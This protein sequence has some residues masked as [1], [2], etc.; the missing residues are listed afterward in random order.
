MVVTAGTH[1]APSIK[2]AEASKIIENTQRDL[3]IALINELTKLF[4]KLD[5][6]INS[7]LSAALT[8]WNFLDFKPGLV[9]GHCIGVDPYYLTFKAKRAGFHPEIILAGRKTNDEFYQFIAQKFIKALV[10]KRINTTNVKVL[11]MGCTFKEDCSDIR[12]SKV[13]DLYDELVQYGCD[14]SIYDPIANAE[15]I[16]DS[17]ILIL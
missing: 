6:N 4:D 15:Q 10:K 17:I 5:I 16:K 2:V 1:R 13:F 7:V 12:N 3:N 9:G 8:K 11:I 14:V